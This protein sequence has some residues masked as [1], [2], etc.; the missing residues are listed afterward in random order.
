MDITLE[1]ELSLPVSCPCSR[2]PYDV[3]CNCADEEKLLGV[4][5]HG[6]V[7]ECPESY[8]IELLEVDGLPNGMTVG[9]IG[10]IEF[11]RLHRE[12]KELA[13]R[14][15]RTLESTPIILSQ[16]V[17]DLRETME[18]AQAAD[19]RIMRSAI[20]ETGARMAL[21]SLEILWQAVRS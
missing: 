6:V 21:A 8:S 12:L 14:H 7:Y 13:E 5:V 1:T 4:T 18:R 20:Y 9:D 2:A 3:V 15:W 19:D 10:P 17:A 16:V 11:E